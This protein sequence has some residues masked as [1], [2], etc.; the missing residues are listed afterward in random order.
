MR[1]LDD[2]RALLE[3]GARCAA[4]L[5]PDHVANAGENKAERVRTLRRV[6]EL[7]RAAALRVELL[8]AWARAPRVS[9]PA[10]VV[11]AILPGPPPA[12]ATEP[13]SWFELMGVVLGV[14]GGVIAVR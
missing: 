5:S 2:A 9:P 11:R 13:G 3:E 4:Y 6:S 7:L 14:D 12:Q 10:A 8:L 1:A